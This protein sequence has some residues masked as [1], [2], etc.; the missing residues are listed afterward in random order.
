MS[1]YGY[2]D[3]MVSQPRSNENS[4]LT[5]EKE[6]KGVG[7]DWSKIDFDELMS[8]TDWWGNPYKPYTDLMAGERLE[9]LIKEE[10]LKKAKERADKEK[11]KLGFGDPL[12]NKMWIVYGLIAVAGYFAYK[13]FKK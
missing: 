9:Q 3:P 11:T 6:K 12:K 2:T 13:K 1:L 4:V 8:D 10:E 7:I 5:Y